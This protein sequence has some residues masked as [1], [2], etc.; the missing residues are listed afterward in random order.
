[1]SAVI[2]VLSL[3]ISMALSGCA[4]NDPKLRTFP[5][6]DLDLV[7]ANAAKMACTCKFVMEMDDAFCVNWVRSSPDVARYSYDAKAKTVEASAFI[8][9]AAHAHYV[10]SKRGCVLE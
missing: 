1:M 10:D 3:T 7:V 6:N 4:V 2:R 8:G 9:W 5:T